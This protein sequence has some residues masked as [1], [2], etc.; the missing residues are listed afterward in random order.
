M[1]VQNDA[2]KKLWC[3]FFFVTSQTNWDLRRLIVEVSR[4]HTFQHSSLGRTPL[5]EGSAR[6]RGLY[7]TTHEIHSGHATVGVR[8]RNRSNQTATMIVPL[9]QLWQIIIM[10]LRQIYILFFF[11]H[12]TTVAMICCAVRSSAAPRCCET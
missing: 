8:T 2:N 10:T 9:V 6:P 3:N 12:Q 4:S 7:I 11:A 5:D 1:S